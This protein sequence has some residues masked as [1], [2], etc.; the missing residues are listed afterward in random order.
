MNSYIFYISVLITIYLEVSLCNIIKINEISW[1]SY[2]RSFPGLLID[3]N[4]YSTFKYNTQLIEKHNS[5][6]ENKWGV[7]PFIHIPYESF[8]KK[9][10]ISIN[11]SPEIYNYPVSKVNKI[12]ND[13]PNGKYFSWVDKNV[14]NTNYYIDSVSWVSTTKQ[15]IES[16]IKIRYDSDH[17][18]DMMQ[19]SSCSNDL[20]NTL[21]RNSV[22]PILINS[23]KRSKNEIDKC[24]PTIDDEMIKTGY[25]NIQMRDIDLNSVHFKLSL[26]SIFDIYVSPI[27]IS[28]LVSDLNIL[29]LQFY[30]GS[31]ILKLN[32]P[33]VESK[34]S[35]TNYSG[36]IVGYGKTSEG[37][38]YWFVQMNMG[39]MWG[40]NGLLKL[41]PFSSSII[42]GYQ[43]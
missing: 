3:S 42:H 25:N 13:L 41:S 8:A 19:I 10:D 23:Y 30:D 37:E 17:N 15:L 2:V 26:S 43:F 24:I 35:T 27:A 28:L 33:I 40:F 9:F 14:I 7:T 39:K 5:I 18:V 36:I 21:Q 29:D 20:Y 12:F 31:Y 22:N 34:S 4:S 16:S 11:N 1:Y 38:E 32:I 6:S